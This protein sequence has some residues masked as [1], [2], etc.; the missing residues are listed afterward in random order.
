MKNVLL[1]LF[2][3]LIVAIGYAAPAVIT[4]QPEGE[5]KTYLR[6]GTSYE[7]LWGFWDSKQ[8]GTNTQLVYAEDGKTVYWKDPL[9]KYINGSWIK[10]ELNA[11]GTKIVF[12]A[13]QYLTYDEKRG[14][15]YQLY[16][17][18]DVVLDSYGYRY[19]SFTADKNTDIT[20]SV[21]G[22]TLRL[23]G[24][25]AEKLSIIAAI[26][27]DDEPSWG[28]YGDAETVLTLFEVLPVVAPEGLVTSTYTFRS[29]SSM[30]IVN[31]GIDGN[32]LYI[33][34]IY[35][36]VPDAWVKGTIDGN[37]VTITSGQYLGDDNGDMLYWVA[38][39]MEEVWNDYWEDYDKVYTYADCM[40][41]EFNPENGT[42]AS[43]MILLANKGEKEINRYGTYASPILTPYVEKAMTPADPEIDDYYI[44]EDEDEDGSVTFYIYT[45]SVDGE[46]IAPENL[47]YRL[48]IDNDELYTL[49][50]DDY[51]YLTEDMSE[52]NYAFTEDWDFSVNTS[53]GKHKIYLYSMFDRIGVQ[54]ICRAGGEERV[55]A[56]VY[57]DGTVVS[58]V[59]DMPVQTGAVCTE[60]YDLFGRRTSLDAQNRVVIRRTV[61]AKGNVSSEKILKK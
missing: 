16:F 59:A 23:E 57:S 56:I 30:N 22:N 28:Y 14:F 33:Q 21:E 60:Y 39:T 13:G 2:A 55:S 38:A 4:E 45:R 15:G 32:D 34:G 58:S 9:S 6:S 27:D 41:F 10:G 1:T 25:N 29:N 53:T 47:Y 50:A 44:P 31:L 51:E 19:E 61:D 40:T 7:N 43:D 26:T 12:P 36:N 5:L 11:D 54:V 20:L 8:D 49:R 24:T 35:S 52:F 18:K 48:Y 3:S 17:I 42:Y 46:D 37:T